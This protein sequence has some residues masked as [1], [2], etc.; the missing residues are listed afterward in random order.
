MQHLLLNIISVALKNV[1]KSL[2][3]V[4]T[5][6]AETWALKV[7]RMLRMMYGVTLNDKVKSTK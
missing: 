7:D 6:G 3:S 2:R 1:R 5:F 4:L